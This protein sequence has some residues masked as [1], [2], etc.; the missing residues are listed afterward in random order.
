MIESRLLQRCVLA[1]ERRAQE[2][3]LAAEPPA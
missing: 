1:L 3:E 2:P